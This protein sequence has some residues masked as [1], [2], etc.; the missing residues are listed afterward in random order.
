MGNVHLFELLIQYSKIDF[1][2]CGHSQYRTKT[3]IRTK[4]KNPFVDSFGSR[5]TTPS[6]SPVLIISHQ[7]H[8]YSK[9]PDISK[10]RTRYH[11]FFYQKPI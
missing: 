4:A 8:N 1:R 3:K 11:P 6:I 2:S 5:V 10:S 9:I 7:E